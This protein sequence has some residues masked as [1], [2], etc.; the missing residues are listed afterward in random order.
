[1]KTVFKISWAYALLIVVWS[2]ANEGLEDGN[3]LG[4]SDGYSLKSYNNGII[5]SY[6]NETVLKWNELVGTYIDEKIPQPL[7]AKIYA[8]VTLT[9]H[10]AL[11]NVVPKY[12]TY[13][14]DNTLVDA[15]A[16]SK[17]NIHAIADAAVSQ[18]TRDIFAALFPPGTSGANSLLNTILSQIEDSESKSKG[19]DIGKAAAAAMLEKRQGDFPLVF[20]TFTGTGIAP[21]D[22]QANFMP[23][24]LPN[25]PIWPANAVY[26]PNLGDLTPFGIN[27][28]NQFRDEGSYPISSQAY[29]DDYNEVKALGCTNCPE[30]TPEQ[31]EIGTFWIENTASMM[32]RI[33]RTLIQQDNLNGWEAARLIALVEMSQIDGFIASFEGKRYFNFWRPITAVRAGDNDGNPETIGDPT[34]TPTHTTPPTPE[35]PST[36]SYC[37]GAGAEVLKLFFGTDTKPFT[38]TSPYY[39]AGVERNITSFSQLARENAE[40]RIYIGYHFRHAIEVGERQGKQ[41]GNYVFKNNLRELKKVL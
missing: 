36:H 27:T 6:S 30:R 1:M 5:K 28:G 32:N 29:I 22:Y 31:T 26:A 35:Y 41:L 9:M 7:E 20:S 21:G 34:W 24:M 37:G 17:K 40:S 12:E 19:I 14:L 33:A 15:S 38:A 4:T 11:N 25:P 16:I 39:L 10:D 23:W 2:C 13:A 3:P 8:M 18:A